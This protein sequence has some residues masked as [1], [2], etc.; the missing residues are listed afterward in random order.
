[1]FEVRSES[2]SSM[3]HG[4]STTFLEF[5]FF[6]FHV[7]DRH[8]AVEKDLVENVKNENVKRKKRKM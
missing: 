3:N 5:L 4:D 7:P 6:Q 8:N 1:M 2:S